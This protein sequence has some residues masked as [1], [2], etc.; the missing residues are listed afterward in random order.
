MT[1]SHDSSLI[2]LRQQL[3]A[4]LDVRALQGSSPKTLETY[5]AQLRPFIEWCEQRA[6]HYAPQVSLP[7]LESWQ[8]YL[9]SYRKPDGQLYSNNSQRERLG[10]LRLWFRHLLQRHHILYNPAELLVLPKEEKRLPAQVLSESETEQVLTSLD[11]QTPMGLR[12][13]AILEILWSSG[14]RRGELRNLRLND[15]DFGRGAVMVRQGKGH[16]DRVIPIGERALD[17]VDRY[18][19]DARPRLTLRDDSGHLFVTKWGKPISPGM[20]TQIAAEAIREQAQLDKPGACHL[21]RHSMATQMLDNGAD[22]RHIQAMLGHEK[23]NTTQI[24]TRVAIKQL[25]QVHSQT[26]PAERAPQ[27]QP[28]A[29]NHTEPPENGSG[30]ASGESEAKPTSQGT[31]QPNNPR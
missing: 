12:N 11:T 17:W 18:V 19:A 30:R 22:I 1:I 8:R 31:G 15:L 23:I 14:I 24:Y 10:T 2:T 20:L 3:E 9:R 27:T 28:D 5:R 16:K 4:W 6:V 7:L 29:D 26:H 13:R 21:F 25:K